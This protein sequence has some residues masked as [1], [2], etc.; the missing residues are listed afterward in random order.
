MEA[1]DRIIK[2][3]APKQSALQQAEQELRV[4]MSGLEEKRGKL[5]AVVD[6]LDALNATLDRLYHEKET[7]LQRVD[8]CEK[9][10][11]RA[12]RLL[13][14]LGGEKIRWTRVVQELDQEIVNSTGDVLLSAGMVAYFSPLSQQL[15][16]DCMQRWIKCL[17]SH[18]IPC[19]VP[20]NLSSV[21]GT[22]SEIQQWQLSGLPAD[23][24][25]TNNALILHN[26]RRWP[27]LIDPQG[28][29]NYWIRSM[30][31]SKG[32]GLQVT[33]FFVHSNLLFVGALGVFAIT[34]W[35]NVIFLLFVTRSGN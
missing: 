25:S 33:I 2:I 32:Q 6:R 10:L 14:G 15:R 22:P 28:Q 13:T 17:N 34:L 12:Q 27:L 8:G 30:A 7:L 3:V 20:F 5:K 1:Y 9:Q 16:N 21:L 31:A 24:F 18:D 35:S 26:S 19:T 29:A 23:D 11:E 4:T